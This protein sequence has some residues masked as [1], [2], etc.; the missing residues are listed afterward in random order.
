MGGK[1]VEQTLLAGQGRSQRSLGTR[2]KEKE[3]ALTAGQSPNEVALIFSCYGLMTATTTSATTAAAGRH[4][5]RGHRTRS[6][7]VYRGK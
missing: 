5:F 2:K 4:T 6:A 7:A 3:K 1:I